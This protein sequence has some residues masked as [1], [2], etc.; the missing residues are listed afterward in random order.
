MVTV[1]DLMDMLLQLPPETRVLTA[2]EEGI[3][4]IE[5]GNLCPF[6]CN[7]TAFGV[8]MYID[9]GTGDHG[10]ISDMWKPIDEFLRTEPYFVPPQN[11]A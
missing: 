3:H 11:P 5:M 2:G 1:K 10:V 9:D 7:E 4:D 8:V 6:K